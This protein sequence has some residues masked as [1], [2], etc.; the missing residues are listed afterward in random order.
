MTLRKQALFKRLMNQSGEHGSDEGGTETLEVEQPD[1]EPEPEAVDDDAS[2]QEPE[3]EATPEPEEVTVTIGSDPAED[4]EDDRT[5]RPWVREL[6]KTN[7][8]NKQRIRELEAQ[9]QSTAPANKPL[10]LGKKPTLEEHDYDA[11]KFEASLTDWFDRKR[12]IEEKQAQHQAELAQQQ[13]AWNAKLD[14]YSKARAALKVRDFE[15]AEVVAQELFN[16]T[17][18]GIVLQGADNPALVIYAL[19]KNPKKAKE[20][21]AITDPVKFAFAVARLEKEMK[22]TPKKSAPPPEKVPTGTGRTSGAVDSTLERLRAQAEKTGDYT[23]VAAY[24]RQKRG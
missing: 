16:V 14:D 21:S 4:E 24:K 12:K 23:K 6:R 1:D 22:V 3:P 20:L 8:E 18:Q 13:A 19:G 5:A 11:E 2:E 9:L 10:E 7:R 15:D 17:Q